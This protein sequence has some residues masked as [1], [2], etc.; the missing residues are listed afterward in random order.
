MLT[1][2]REPSAKERSLLTE[3]LARYRVRFLAKPSDAEEMLKVGDSKRASRIPAPE[4]AA[5]MLICSTLM[6]TDEFLT[7][8]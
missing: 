2:G 6:N 4:H 7:L 5:W 1:V 3:A 8:H